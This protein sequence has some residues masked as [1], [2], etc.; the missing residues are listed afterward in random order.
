MEGQA[1][2][3]SDLNTLS[4]ARMRRLTH[5]LPL[6]DAKAAGE[7]YLDV[8]SAS[9]FDLPVKNIDGER[10]G[11]KYA[12]L[13]VDAYSRFRRVY[14][15]KS[16]RELPGL[17]RHYLS[18]LGASAHA[19]GLFMLGDGFRRYVHTDGGTPMNSKAFEKVLLE[20]GL[21]ANV[22]SCLH[23]PA[24]NGVA[25]RSFGTLEPDV[26]AKLAMSSLSY[27]HWS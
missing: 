24:S 7:T 14:F 25:E 22:T 3:S 17:A 15:A 5:E 8:Y 6:P 9:K 2:M 27:R 21:A 4:D 1:P 16:Q 23:T 20:F 10:S 11:F 13:F 18:E 19:G 26:R 12:I